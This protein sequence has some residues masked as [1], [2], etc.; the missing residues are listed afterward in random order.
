MRAVSTYTAVETANV[1]LELA[2]L[3]LGYQHQRDM[4]R[5]IAAVHETADYQPVAGKG[6]RDIQ[7]L[8]A[9]RR[10]SERGS[11]CA[12]EGSAMMSRSMTRMA[13]CAGKLISRCQQRNNRR[14]VERDF[15]K[16]LGDSGMEDA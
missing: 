4:V 10:R 16:C 6:Q 13:T 14:S 7:N 12:A 11:T 3:D 1:A 5:S 8:T 15:E 2:R 9:S